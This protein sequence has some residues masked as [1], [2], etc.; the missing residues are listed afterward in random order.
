MVYQPNPGEKQS[1]TTDESEVRYEKWYPLP[2]EKIIK[3]CEG[4]EARQDEII[5]LRNKV[6]MLLKKFG[7]GNVNENYT[8]NNDDNKK[9]QHIPGPI[10]TPSRLRQEIGRAQRVA[11]VNQS[12][13]KIEELE[14]V[15]PLNLKETEV[16]E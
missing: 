9:H 4:C 13:Q 7:L 12:R 5:Y 16:S 8:T 10:N 6:D 3:R 15:V 14:N 11:R 1:G 2:D